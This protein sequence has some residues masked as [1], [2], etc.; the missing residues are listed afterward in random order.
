MTPVPSR[1]AGSA[2]CGTPP[3]ANAAAI[4]TFVVSVVAVTN[5]APCSAWKRVI[6]ASTSS[7]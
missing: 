1:A 3:G 6:S 7:M 4:G 5:S 2:R